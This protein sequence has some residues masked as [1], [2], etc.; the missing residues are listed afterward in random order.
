MLSVAKPI[1]AALAGKRIAVLAPDRILAL[2]WSVACTRQGAAP[3]VRGATFDEPEDGLDGALVS[4]RGE[5]LAPMID[6]IARIE[7]RRGAS[8]PCVIVLDA[9]CDATEAAFSLDRPWIPYPVHEDYVLA[10]LSG[11]LGRMAAC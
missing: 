6:G 5:D 2:A 9:A 7:A 11:L 1:S 4:A 8:L 10:A 3:V